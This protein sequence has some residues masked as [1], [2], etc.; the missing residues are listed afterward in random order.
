MKHEHEHSL[1][2]K[3]SKIAEDRYGL[4]VEGWLERN[5]KNNE[6]IDLMKQGKL[7]GL[8]VGFRLINSYYENGIRYITEGELVEISLVEMPANSGAAFVP[9]RDLKQPKLLVRRP[10]D[11][12]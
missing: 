8:S 3:W 1:D 2:G 5:A 6:L 12:V 9:V 4:W 10:R 7:Q 11:Q